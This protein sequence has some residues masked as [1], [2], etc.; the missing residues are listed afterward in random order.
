MKIV[1]DDYLNS[2]ASRSCFCDNNLHVQN[3]VVIGNLEVNT[4]VFVNSNDTDDKNKTDTKRYTTDVTSNQ[5]DSKPYTGTSNQ[6]EPNNL[7]LIESERKAANTYRT[8]YFSPIPI[9][10]QTSKVLTKTSTSRVIS[11]RDECVMAREPNR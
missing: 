5:S 3:N 11:E 10:Y 7:H 6:R 2:H 1:G 9:A 4:Y 8:P